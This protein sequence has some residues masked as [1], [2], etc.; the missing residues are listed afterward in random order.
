MIDFSFDR[1]LKKSYSQH[2]IC[3]VWPLSPLQKKTC[4]ST[5]RAE[6]N[7]KKNYVNYLDIV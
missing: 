3:Q 5:V 7:I 6:L 2:N 4:L 1:L